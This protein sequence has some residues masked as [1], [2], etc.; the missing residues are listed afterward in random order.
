MKKALFNKN[1]YDNG[2]VKY[3]AGQQYDLTEDAER[4]VRRGHAEII[5]VKAARKGTAK[6]I[7]AAKKALAAAEQT[8]LIA[9]EALATAA[10]A[11]VPAAQ[12]A[13]SAAEAEVETARSALADLE[14]EE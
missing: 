6:Q 8:A 13:V 2:F 10:D 1:I 4:Q 11:D 3:A 14:G 7:A 12:Q 9:R 5:E